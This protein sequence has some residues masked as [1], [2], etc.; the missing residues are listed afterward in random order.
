MK[1][2][3]IIF[4]VY[5]VLLAAK[6]CADRVSSNFEQT[7]VVEMNNDQDS[8]SHDLD[9]C[10]PFCICNCCG[11]HIM[12]LK[13]VILFESLPMVAFSKTPISTYRA[14]FFPIF[15]NSIWQPPQLNA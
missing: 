6:P 7:I 1:I 2:L 13:T 12:N 14:E 5:F 11:V 4:A 10:S 9:L 3:T 15:S 8:H